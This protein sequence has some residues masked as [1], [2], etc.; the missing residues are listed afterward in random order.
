[1]S[2]ISQHKEMN[3]TERIKGIEEFCQAD[4]QEKKWKW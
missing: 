4:E 3:C 1:M 2:Y